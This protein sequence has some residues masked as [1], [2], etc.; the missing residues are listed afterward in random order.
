MYPQIP[1]KKRL[2]HNAVSMKEVRTSLPSLLE[3]QKPLFTTIPRAHCDPWESLSHHEA[4]YMK[5][6]PTSTV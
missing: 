5:A 6:V 3:G 4:Q 1:R 2:L